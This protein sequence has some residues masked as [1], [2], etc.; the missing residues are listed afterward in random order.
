MSS[1]VMPPPPQMSP[2]P[3]LPPRPHR[4]FAGP[5]V[6]IIIG[7]VFLLGTMKVL[8]V[9]RLAHLFAS[10]WPLL[11]ILWG[12]IKLIEHQ[13]AR[14]EGT[15][16][17]G[18]GAG[19]VFLV[20]MIVVFGLIATQLERVNWSGL[21]DQINIDDS[22]FNDIFGQSYNF[23]DHLERDFPAGSSLKIIDTRGAVSVHSSDDNK[24][25]VSVRK[26]VGAESQEDAD[27][28]N[29]QTKPTITAIGGLLTLD[30][31]A[32]G[33]GDH[34]VEVDLD[35]SLPRKVPVTI[36]SRKGDV[37]VVGRDGA[38]DISAQHSD[39]SVEDVNGSVKVS[40]E[41]GSV[42]I[43]QITGDVHVEGRV[44]EVSVSDVKGGAQL[45]GEF[46]ESVK[47]ARISK[48]V[49]F[50]SSRTDMEFSRIEGSLDLDSSEL[51]AEEITGPLHLTTRDKNIRLEEV[52]GDVRLQDSD[53]AVEVDMRTL[54][55]VQIDNR[56]GDLQV[57]LPEKAGFRIDAHARDGEIQ[58]DFPGLNVSSGDSETR[59]SGS[60]GNG[61][62]HIVL[63]NEHDNI[64][65]RKAGPQPPK[66]PEPPRAGKTLPPP[67]EKV[68]PTDN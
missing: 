46:Q 65:I 12:L 16:P 55:N 62:S 11:L 25:T 52:S 23:E 24:I 59:A 31:K 21:R 9:S 10:Y 40:Q 35:V 33:S 3:P 61:A 2:L 50:R 44:D 38:V 1:P 13:Q 51:H 47:L 63:N 14:R 29:T 43:E 68:E 54:G 30:A 39:T 64:E 57:A 56:N 22:D 20:V 48:Q 58:S 19:G 53:G 15:R 45:D 7:T 5:L 27:K 42:K 66:A 28:Y 6:L 17:P 4:S 34:A 26:R 41:K 8:S 36:S 60:F 37:S 67:K 32:E 18:I 49:T